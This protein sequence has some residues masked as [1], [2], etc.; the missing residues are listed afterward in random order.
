VSG[1]GLTRAE[2]V[3]YDGREKSAELSASRRETV[4]R[5]RGLTRS[6][7][8]D[9]GTDIRAVERIEA[10]KHSPATTAKKGGSQ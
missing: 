3:E 7:S 9:V 2:V 6:P 8:G 1:R 4:C 5:R 10:G